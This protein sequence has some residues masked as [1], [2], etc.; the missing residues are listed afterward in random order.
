MFVVYLKCF[1]KTILSHVNID[2]QCICLLS[3]RKSTDL[4]VNYVCHQFKWTNRPNQRFLSWRS[5]DFRL[6][7]TAADR[8]RKEWSHRPTERQR[9]KARVAQMPPW[10]WRQ[11]GKQA[12]YRGVKQRAWPCH[13][14]LPVR[15]FLNYLEGR[16]ALSSS[17]TRHQLPGCLCF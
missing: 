12:N 5:S 10:A 6:N 9:E 3:V 2:V 8:N 14:N 16:S 15:D 13:L 7:N 11:S 17:A 4:S 1:T